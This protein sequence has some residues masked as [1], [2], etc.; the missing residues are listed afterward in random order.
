MSEERKRER[1]RAYAGRKM[2]TLVLSLAM[3]CVCMIVDIG[4][5]IGGN[6]QSMN[7]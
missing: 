7:E 1:G 2:T 4:M 6:A 3:K 5:K